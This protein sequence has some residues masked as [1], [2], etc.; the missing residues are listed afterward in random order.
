MHFHI[1]SQFHFNISLK[2]QVMAVKGSVQSFTIKRA[3]AAFGMPFAKS[4]LTCMNSCALP[5]KQL[6]FSNDYFTDF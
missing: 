4:S 3:G 5:Y 2:V 1:Y 6:R